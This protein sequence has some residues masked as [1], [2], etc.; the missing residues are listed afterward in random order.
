MELLVAKRR[1]LQAD[2]QKLRQSGLKRSGGAI[3]VLTVDD[4]QDNKTLMTNETEKD[5]LEEAMALAAGKTANAGVSDINKGER[6]FSTIQYDDDDISKIDAVEA[7][8]KERIKMQ[9]RVVAEKAAQPS[10]S[11]NKAG[12][13]DV[14]HPD[15][16]EP[17]T[18]LDFVEQ[19]TMKQIDLKALKEVQKS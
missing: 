1:E 2:Q 3:G 11:G 6:N 7:A 13:G 15:D 12:R 17:T 8:T 9:R 10:Q 14:H 16:D 4:N 18:T 19:E 5:V